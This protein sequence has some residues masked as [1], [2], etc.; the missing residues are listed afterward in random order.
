MMK[1]MINVI[2]VSKIIFIVLFCLLFC[3]SSAMKSTAAFVDAQEA[4]NIVENWL[5]RSNGLSGDIGREIR[6]YVHYHGPI[7]GEPGGYVF[8]LDPNGWVVVPADD[9]FEPIL[10]FGSG[11][12]TPYLYELLPFRHLFRIDVSMQAFSTGLKEET[13]KNKADIERENRWD[14]LL[15]STSRV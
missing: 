3:A 12:L 11:K 8:F 5:M 9:A 10:A 7:Q 2:K 6:E 1:N 14:M 13:K 15:K 4:Q